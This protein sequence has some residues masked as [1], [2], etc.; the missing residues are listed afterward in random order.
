M[1][2]IL[3]L[4]VLAFF[5]TQTTDGRQKSLP[6]K[7]LFENNSQ[8]SDHAQ[9]SEHVSNVLEAKPP[10]HNNKEKSGGTND[11]KTQPEVPR[12]KTTE[13]KH[14]V[15]Y[16]KNNRGSSENPTNTVLISSLNLSN[17]QHVVI[18]EIGDTYTIVE[19]QVDEQFVREVMRR[20]IS[21]FRPRV[22][23][24]SQ[25]AVLAII[26]QNVQNPADIDTFM[27]IQLE[28]I[29][30]RFAEPTRFQNQRC[31]THSEVIV[32]R[33]RPNEGNYDPS[34]LLDSY[35][36][37]NPNNPPQFAVL[38]TWIHPCRGCSAQIINTFGQGGGHTPVWN[39]P[40][41]IGRT[42]AGTYLHP[43]LTPQERQDITNMLLVVALTLLQI[44]C[45]QE[46]DVALV[47]DEPELCD[48]CI[49]SGISDIFNCNEEEKESEHDELCRIN[50]G[51]TT[52]TGK[53]CKS[54]NECGY[55]DYSYAWCYTTDGSWDYCCT[56]SCGNHDNT[57]YDWC[58]SG[59]TWQY[60]VRQSFPYPTLTTSGKNCRSGSQCGF[61][62]GTAY[63]WCYTTFSD[64]WDYCCASECEQ[65][66][67]KYDWCTTGTS[68][69]KWQYC[70][71]EISTSIYY[72]ATGKS[73]SSECGY[74]GKNYFWC[75][76][77]DGS[78]DYCCS[79]ECDIHSPSQSY[80]WCT[81]G[82]T[83]SQCQVHTLP[84]PQYTYNLKECRSNNKCGFHGEKD[85]WCYTMDGS[86]DY[87]CT[88]NCDLH[89]QKYDWCTTGNSWQH[90]KQETLPE[91]HITAI[92]DPCLSN[93]ICGYHDDYSYPWCYT[94]SSW[95]YCCSSTCGKY[96]TTQNFCAAGKKTV[97]SCCCSKYG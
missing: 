23:H 88:Q 75:N 50:A 81:S 58:I 17:S 25:F 9:P 97:D 14:V 41:Y 36:R 51:Q 91:M 66:N 27:N 46:Y 77:N 2:G 72:S 1:A 26:P 92:G 64:D 59:N 37:N 67:Q 80:D 6:T 78:W 30:Y 44:N 85:A 28:N 90:C 94:E 61:H 10:P 47:Q 12:D 48:T 60:C 21:I 84:Y 89:G 96:G 69:S 4:V 8:L 11:N 93:S 5:L 57:K 40:T 68:S 20:I 19:A 83:W 82:N 42:T 7:L 22:Q 52:S 49:L 33:G 87:C 62:D 65:Y 43:P 63:A 13:E 34:Q 86:W 31:R 76:T 32:M 55:H 39:I 73:C 3:R 74:H 95:D 53:T 18:R 29:N 35:T 45:R 16:N 71:R 79:G 15:S 70:K 54:D 24:G 38:Y 56:G